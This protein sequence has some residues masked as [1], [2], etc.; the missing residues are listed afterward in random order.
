MVACFNHGLASSDLYGTYIY[1]YNIY[2]YIEA[3]YTR[4]RKVSLRF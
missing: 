2:I 4:V 3:R 1:V